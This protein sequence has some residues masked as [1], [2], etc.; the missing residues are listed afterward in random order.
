METSQ[1]KRVISR[2]ISSES[3][4]WVFPFPGPPVAARVSD[5]IRDGAERRRTVLEVKGREAGV[6]G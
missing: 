1:G 3:H 2:N 6:E 5:R 4:T